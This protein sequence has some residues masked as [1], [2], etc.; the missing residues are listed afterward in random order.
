AVAVTAASADDGAAAPRALAQLS[1]EEFPRL[2]LLWAGT[3]DHHHAL[4][5]W[6][7]ENAHY[8]LGGG[9]RPR[10]P[11]GFGALPGRRAV[12]AGVAWAEG[13][14]GGDGGWGEGG[15]VGGGDDPAGDDP[16][17]AQPPLP[18][19]GLPRV[20]LPQSWLIRPLMGQTVSAA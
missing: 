20:P 8:G 14:G 2:R 10:G 5:G 15:G 1:R 4:H 13:G 6:L 7:G 9:S 18:E 19:R 12:G 11:K 17:D 3:K 16:Y